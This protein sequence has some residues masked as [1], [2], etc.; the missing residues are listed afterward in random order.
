MK[1]LRNTLRFIF[2]TFFIVTG[3]YTFVDA[4]NNVLQELEE[5]AIVDQKVM[6]PMGDGIR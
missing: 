1:N 2:L 3:V 6:M 5:I 4:Q